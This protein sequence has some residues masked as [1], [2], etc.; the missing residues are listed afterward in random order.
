MAV[1]ALSLRCDLDILLLVPES[2][3]SVYSRGDLDNRIKTLVDGLRLPTNE[4]EVSDEVDANSSTSP[5]DVLLEDDRLIS[6]ITAQS[7]ILLGASVEKAST[8]YSRALIKVNL[9]PAAP[10]MDTFSL[11]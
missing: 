9:Y 10:N 1:E 11:L 2:G 5:L 3:F 4:Q 6:K 7:D 8:G